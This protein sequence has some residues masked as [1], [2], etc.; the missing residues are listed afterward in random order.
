WLVMNAI[1]FSLLA[2]AA[3]RAWVEMNADDARATLGRLIVLLPACWIVLLILAVAVGAVSST[4]DHFWN[5]VLLAGIVM[6]ICLA[7]LIV[8]LL[9]PNP[10][11]LGYGLAVLAGAHLSFCFWPSLPRTPAAEVFPETPLIQSL[12]QTNRRIV[13]S[14]LLR[15]WPLLGNLVPQVYAPSGIHLAHVD[16]FLQAADQDPLLLRRA[17]SEYLLL[18][19]EDIRGPYARLR[20]RLDLEKVYPQGASLF[21]DT[22]G[23]GRAYT[24]H[25]ARQAQ[26]D[27]G[28][29]RPDSAELP[30][31]EGLAPLEGD[32]DTTAKA[33]ISSETFTQVVVNV[34]DSPLGVLVLADAWYPGWHA[35][36]NGEAREIGRV[37]GAFRGVELDEG[38]NEIVF[39]YDPFSFRIGLWISAAAALLVVLSMRHIFF[40]LRKRDTLILSERVTR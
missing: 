20:P 8:T 14:P 40:G 10:R 15:Q 9:K 37:E 2:A 3:V 36:V 32:G 39:F 12:Q 1:V 38:D 5:Q 24:I 23:Q 33:G 30:L 19:G 28:S 34:E 13:G 25:R 11:L 18:S 27:T 6:I 17:G 35:N 7:L 22:L 31:I 21:S 29:E 26:A 4:P 16:R